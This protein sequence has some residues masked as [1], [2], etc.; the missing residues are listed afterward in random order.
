MIFILG[1]TLF[2][3]IT[4]SYVSGGL[5]KYFMLELVYLFIIATVIFIMPLPIISAFL[6][7]GVLVFQG[8]FSYININLF[9]KYGDFFTFDLFAYKADF[10]GAMRFS[11][12]ELTSIGWLIGAGVVIV[13]ALVFVLFGIKAKVDFKR[14]SVVSHAAVLLFCACFAPVMYALSVNTLSVEAESERAIALD[15]RGLY[16]NMTSKNAYFYKFGFYPFYIRNGFLSM[17]FGDTEVPTDTAKLIEYFSTDAAPEANAYTGIDEGNNLIVMM[18]E[19]CDSFM[20]DEKYT[21]TLYKVFNSGIQLSQNYNQA[22]T[23]YA[24]AAVIL[25]SYPGANKYNLVTAWR[26]VDA[27]SKA[28]GSSAADYYAF[29]LA[30][31]LKAD[32][33]EQTGYFHLNEG[34]F[35]SRSFTHTD[36]GFDN[37]YF[38]KE[39]RYYDRFWDGSTDYRYPAER[40][41]GVEYERYNYVENWALPESWFLADHIDEFM[42]TDKR[43]F[44]FMTTIH[45]H[46]CYN[47]E[48]LTPL[49][50]VYYDSIDTADLAGIDKKL[51]EPYKVA[52]AMA[53]VLDDSVR[54]MLD[55]LAARGLS[56]KTTVLFYADHNAYMNSMAY[57]VR[58]SGLTEPRTFKIPAAILSPDAGDVKV[59]KF[60]TAFDY[61]PTLLN[62][63]GIDYNQN[64]YAGYDAFS[65]NKSVV[66]SKIGGVFDENYYTYD[67]V[68]VLGKS[69][70]ATDADFN[71][72]QTN[73]LAVK[74]RMKKIA[75]LYDETQTLQILNAIPV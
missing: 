67:L 7:F 72:Y 56:D 73:Y 1:A 35:Y 34:N 8:I 62:L 49:T 42:P 63:F 60:T 29:S 64:L 3:V 69:D 30:H 28:D 11:D 33:V 51:H 57:L 26:D 25:G 9:Q 50:R 59:D 13:T 46:G 24:E 14:Q 66:I 52:L 27:K 70:G 40:A 12:F 44:S 6:C 16:E 10:G 20:V 17:P 21:P 2:E 23:D 41:S 45:A 71:A 38:P 15:D 53:M 36:F 58:D 48:R 61:T 54:Y 75:A 47:E 32:G 4:F 68:E 37:L 19:S 43:F 31:K 65:Q 22:K 39:E 74:E 5:P 55:E 18:L